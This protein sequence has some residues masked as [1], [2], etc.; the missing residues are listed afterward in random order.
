MQKIT[1]EAA[2]K[3]EAVHEI[4]AY[5]L[6]EKDE[7]IQRIAKE[8]SELKDAISEINKRLAGMGIPS[9]IVAVK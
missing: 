2:E 4:Q 9:A 5:F 8:N 7:E 1:L 6:K 3:K